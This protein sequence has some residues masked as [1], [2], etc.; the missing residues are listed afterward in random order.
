M[1]PKE[2]AFQKALADAHN[3]ARKKHEKPPLTVAPLLVKAA[4]E[5]AQDMANFVENATFV[6]QLD[7]QDAAL[8]LIETVEIGGVDVEIEVSQRESFTRPD[9][10]DEPAFRACE[11]R[12]GFQFD[13]Q[14]RQRRTIRILD[15]QRAQQRHRILPRGVIE[16]F[17]CL[18]HQS[19]GR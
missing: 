5:H 6:N 12:R 3:A 8:C 18:D 19:R 4:Y 11:A 16:C 17:R 10:V 14:R 1:T 9:A 2:K 13:D 15:D 7:S